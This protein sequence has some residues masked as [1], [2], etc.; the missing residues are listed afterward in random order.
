MK[1]ISY[2]VLAAIMGGVI[3]SGF[4]YLL[5]PKA[6]TQNLV[7][8]TANMP[9]QTTSSN[10]IM[11]SEAVD[12]RDAAEKSVHAVVHIKSAAI[13][14]KLVYGYRKYYDPLEELL[15]ID[16]GYYLREPQNKQET[17][18]STGSG[19]II[20]A[21][22]YI[23]TNNHV[24]EDADE[25]EVVTNHNQ[26]FKA[27]VIGTD[28]STDIAV[29]KIEGKNMPYLEFTNSD[30]ISIGEW[31]LAVGNPF[32]LSSTVTAGIVSAKARNIN[33]LKER[34]AIESFIQTDAAVNPGNSGGALVNLEGKLIG[35]NTAIASPTGAFAGYSFAVPS[36]MVQKVAEDLIK[37]G[38]VQRAFL[39]IQLGEINADVAK[40]LGVEITQGIYIEEVLSGGAAEVSGLKK[41]D[42]ITKI[43]NT[44]IKTQAQLLEKLSSF[45]PG[46]NIN[47]SIIRNANAMSLEVKLR[48]SQGTT[49]IVKNEG[50]YI[51]QQLGLEIEELSNEEKA[52]YSINS[53]VVVKKIGTGLVQKSTKM[54]EGFIILTAN[55]KSVKN[56]KQF[57]DILNNSAGGLLLEGYYPGYYG[58]YYYAVE[59]KK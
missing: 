51:L 8:E 53:G 15:G 6:Q 32:N 26:I 31:V 48:N 3:A 41:K 50:E 4:N 7:Q 44:E 33:I 45:R 24:I 42:I 2:L 47:I 49:E 36:N 17:Q 37:F 23:V 39:G 55:G 21:D 22:G 5:L 56:E 12:F 27:T 34:T 10:V 35:I 54:K 13:V 9:V 19:V 25:L 1:K 28:P 46:D 18:L 11:A 52:K 59:L 30:N 40:E 14:N 20:S 29:L 57:L 16:R 43:N 58:K 38:V